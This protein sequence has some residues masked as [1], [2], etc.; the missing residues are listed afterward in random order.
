MI[1]FSIS[2][3]MVIQILA[4][5]MS[6][7][8]SLLYLRRIEKQ[9]EQKYPMP[10]VARYHPLTLAAFD[11][12]RNG[13][14]ITA[15]V[16]LMQQ[17]LLRIGKDDT[18]P[19][20]VAEKG[21]VNRLHPAE[22]EIYNVLHTSACHPFD[23][24]KTFKQS[25]A[26]SKYIAE[27]NAEL[28]ESHLVRSDAEMRA[29][30]QAGGVASVIFCAIIVPGIIYSLRFYAEGASIY[31]ILLMLALLA[32]MPRCFVKG[33]SQNSSRWDRY[34][35]ALKKQ[36]ASFYEEFST[37]D[38]GI[39][40]A[41]TIGLSGM[42]VLK[43]PG[44][45]KAFEALLNMFDTSARWDFS[46]VNIIERGSEIE[47]SDLQDG[48]MMKI[49]AIKRDKIMIQGSGK[50]KE[51]SLSDIECLTIDHERMADSPTETEFI[52]Q[53]VTKRGEKAQ[54]FRT[55]VGADLGLLEA[56]YVKRTF[57]QHLD[58]DRTGRK[59]SSSG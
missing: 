38:V 5:I 59:T 47:I 56:R 42:I 6:F 14:V 46:G 43:D 20:L 13:L 34:R 44:R 2:H 8:A 1:S 24:F 28:K 35:D 31:L 11:K 29:S 7:V 53:V 39:G 3:P 51:I 9:E 36:Y 48:T 18:G 55:H 52:V 4:I 21:D 10:D 16:G 32:L 27:A 58:L 26:L 45:K 40:P 12:N 25:D 50:S 23:V 15:L 37:A 57:E 22:M 19:V 54:I 33:A 30:K 17:N 41:A 49:T